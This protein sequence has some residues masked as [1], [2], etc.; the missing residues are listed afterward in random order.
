MTEGRIGQ[1]RIF[2]GLAVTSGAQQE[3]IPFVDRGLSVEYELARSVRVVA[4]TARRKVGVLKTD[5]KLCGGFF[6]NMDIFA[7][8][9]SR[10][11][12]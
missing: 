10:A 4:K 6:C 11:F 1:R 3:V 2:M 8:L 12:L 7:K 9:E 5:A